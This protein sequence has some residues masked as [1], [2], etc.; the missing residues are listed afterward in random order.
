LYLYKTADFGVADTSV[1]H[2]YDHTWD[3]YD[4]S[5]LTWNNQVCGT[6]FNDS[7][8]C[9]LVAE[10]TQTVT[11]PLDVWWNWI[12]TSM[13]KNEY[14][15][16]D[17]DVSI[18]LKTSE[19]CGGWCGSRFAPKEHATAAYRPYIKIVY[20]KSL[21]WVDTSVGI[22]TTTPA[23]LFSVQGDSYVSGDSYSGTRSGGAIDVAEWIKYDQETPKPQPGQVICVSPEKKETVEV[24]QASY[25][26]NIVGVVSTNPHLTMGAELAGEDAVVMALTGRVPV[27]VSLENGEIKVGD[28]L[29]SASST[30]GA[31]MK[32]IKPGRVLGMALESF[33][34]MTTTSQIMVS[35]NPHWWGGSLDSLGYL[36][37]E[38]SVTSTVTTTDQ[39]I[40]I[41]FLSGL[42]EGVWD[43]ITNASRLVVNGI[44][45]VKDDISTRGVFK[46]VIKV[47]KTIIEGRTITIE[48]AVSDSQLEIESEDEESVSFVTYSITAPRKE[49]ML[50]GSGA[51]LMSSEGKAEAKIVFHTSF[52]YILSDLIPI[53]VIIT[54]TSYINGQLYV[55]EKSIYGFTIKEINSQDEGAQFDWIVT[56]RLIDFDLAQ[57]VLAST[58]EDIASQDIPVEDVCQNGESRA[59]GEAVGIC[60]VGLQICDHGVWDE[61]FGN[62]TPEEEICD[63]VDNNC[64]GQIDEIELCGSSQEPIIEEIEDI[65]DSTTTESAEI[66]TEETSTSTEPII[67]EIVE[68][69]V[70]T[71]EPVKETIDQGTEEIIVP[72]EQIVEEVTTTRDEEISTTELIIE[73][74]SDL[75]DAIIDETEM[76][77]EQ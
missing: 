3:G 54:P 52:S 50:S 40:K 17:A 37:I 41:T 72:M 38:S 32:A 20:G 44:L 56:A 64:D 67:E 49:I 2:V 73:T 29:T 51:L 55:A 75:E 43:K 48:N 23:R 12:I 42:L 7:G 24:C 31:A 71:T 14:D 18:A 36:N 5:T 15:N 60:T 33:S 28:L 69:I 4:E 76:M 35:I 61:C 66:L 47:A 16:G 6:A 22:G 59:C 62:V 34:E 53:K 46:Q 58:T 11:A 26:Q 8:D 74:V 68:L 25:G 39:E 70:T 57:Q 19:D 65:Q 21:L 63:G 9:N 30:A 10:D 77:A 27:K 13:V 1:H 45:E